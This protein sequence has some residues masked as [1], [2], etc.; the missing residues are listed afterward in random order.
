MRAQIGDGPLNYVGSY[1]PGKY[2]Y[3]DIYKIHA[4]MRQEGCRKFL[5]SNGSNLRQIC[6]RVRVASPTGV[7]ETHV[8]S[9]IED[10]T[11]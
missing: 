9:K 5:T 4:K 8:F 7:G 3:Q 1:L 11:P 2:Q 10:H 6:S